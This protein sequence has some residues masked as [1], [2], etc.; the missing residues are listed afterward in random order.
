M[1]EP[2]I[3]CL[4]GESLG[5]LRKQ[6]Y[7]ASEFIV[8]Y[9]RA[10]DNLERR[11]AQKLMAAEPVCAEQFPLLKKLQEMRKEKAAVMYSKNAVLAPMA[12]TAVV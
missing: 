7:G 8:L 9:A 6:K 3:R 11:L 5:S 4:Y 12:Q 2:E 1:R 10:C